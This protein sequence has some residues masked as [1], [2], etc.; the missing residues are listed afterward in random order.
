MFPH[1][2]DPLP[3]LTTEEAIPDPTAG[4]PVSPDERGTVAYVRI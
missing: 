1:K 2:S 4:T 3:S